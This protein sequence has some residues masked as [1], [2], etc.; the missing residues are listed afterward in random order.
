ME[1]MPRARHTGGGR[2]R[3]SVPSLGVPP[4]TCQHI[5]V[6]TN[7]EVPPRCFSFDQDVIT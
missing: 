4:P 7:T 5:I 3:A 1:E 6:F 2:C